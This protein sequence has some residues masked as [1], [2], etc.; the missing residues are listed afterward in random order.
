MKSNYSKT[1]FLLIGVFLLN[2]WGSKVYKRF[3][4]TEDSRYSLSKTTVNIANKVE[5]I[6]LIK[7]YLQGDFPADF[8]RLQ[9]ETKSHLE[10]LK[11]INNKI[12]FKFINP[13]E[14]SE[15]LIKSGLE[16]SSL[17]VQEDAS[18]S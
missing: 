15:E 16:P 8:K 5:D 9:T 18:L 14:I 17:Q 2:F 7:V 4:L 12:Q 3:D 13:S 10:E 6:I 11:S 1:T